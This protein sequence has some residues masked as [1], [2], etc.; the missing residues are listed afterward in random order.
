MESSISFG[1]L[2]LGQL[3]LLYFYIVMKGFCLKGQ[4]LIHWEI[5]DLQ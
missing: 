4:K 5:L 2:H 1:K 3:Y